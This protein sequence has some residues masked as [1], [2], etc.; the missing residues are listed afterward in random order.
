MATTVK[1]KN[2][3]EEAWKYIDLTEFKTLTWKLSEAG[4]SKPETLSTDIQWTMVSP[5]H[6]HLEIKDN[7]QIVAPLN[8]VWTTPEGSLSKPKIT[9]SIGKKAA[10]NL[11]LTYVQQGESACCCEPDLNITLSDEAQCCTVISNRYSDTSYHFE[12]VQIQSSKES[13]YE[14]YWLAQGGRQ[15]RRQVEVDLTGENSHTKLHGLAILTGKSESYTHTTLNHL[16]PH[17]ESHQFFKNILSD[18]A[19]SEFNGLVHVKDIAQKTDAY[20]SN[21]NLLLSDQARALSRP[22]LKIFADDVKCSHGA[23]MGQLDETQLFYLKSR[24]LDFESARSLLLYGFAE[25][26]IETI[27]IPLAKEA[28]EK[29]IQILLAAL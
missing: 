15:T 27:P 5:N 18:S 2:Q 7:I 25:E 12:S 11:V 19:Q 20:Q 29:Q 23:T 10:F 24:G 13:R 9:L 28:C 3:V 17:C 8:L 1:E 16:V 21:H 26:V 6:L 14:G 4:F 22:Q